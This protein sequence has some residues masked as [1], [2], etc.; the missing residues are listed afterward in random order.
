MGTINNNPSFLNVYE[1]MKNYTQPDTLCHTFNLLSNLHKLLPNHLV[2]VLHSYRSESDKIKCEN[3]EL[4][5]MEKILA[6]HMLPRE[7]SLS[8]KPSKMSSWKR[9][10]INNI[11]GNWKKCHMWK[12][13]IYEPPMCTVIARWAKKNMQP[14]EDLK[15]GIQRLS[16]L[17]PIVSV[18][19]CGYQ[20]AVVVFK[21]TTSAC[22]AVSA[23]PTMSAGTMF[24]CSWQHRFMS[25]NKLWS[26]KHPSRI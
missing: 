8:P 7:V 20:S 13:N 17:G 15:S 2:E 25:K 4:S 1:K 14:A 21:D 5:G 12:K 19:P 16:V 18:T 3:S 10:I 26:R 24:Q 23:F 11:S 22:K 9:K 6:R